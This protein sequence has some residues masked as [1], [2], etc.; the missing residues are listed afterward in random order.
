MKRTTK[1]IISLILAVCML[2]AFSVSSFAA[3]VSNL[4][5]YVF[6]SK[7]NTNY[8]LN[9]Y[10]DGT[11][12]SGAAVKAYTYDSSDTNQIWQYYN[13]P[14]TG[15]VYLRNMYTNPMLVLAAS[16][17]TDSNG[18]NVAIV[19]RMNE[20]VYGSAQQFTVG[21]NGGYYYFNNVYFNE[22]LTMT[23]ARNGGIINFQSYLPGY[24]T[25]LWLAD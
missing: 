18:H 6:R 16:G 12:S 5:S 24:S 9:I 4:S 1:R 20:T 8:V 13:S 21:S 17:N 23:E 15:Y 19:E 14:S 22:A 3:N 7:L 10:V 2:S 11:P 25:Q